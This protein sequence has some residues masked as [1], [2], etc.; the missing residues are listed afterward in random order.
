MDNILPQEVALTLCLSTASWVWVEYSYCA[1]VARLFTS[2]MS[3]ILQ[4]YSCSFDFHHILDE[5]AW[6]TNT[7][8][9]LLGRCLL[10][11]VVL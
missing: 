7:E 4:I 11:C 8:A 1:S 5:I 6:E 2:V 3:F 9:D 10:P